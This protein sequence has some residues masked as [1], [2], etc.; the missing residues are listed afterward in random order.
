MKLRT[1]V[2]VD[3]YNLYYGRL[4]N[5]HHK[6]LDLMA[7]TERVLAGIYFG[8]K[9]RTEFELHPLAIKY[10]TASILA[11]FAK[12]KDSVSD[13]EHYHQALQ[14]HSGGA[15]QIIKGVYDASPAKAHLYQKGEPA[16]A[17]EKVEI[18]KLVEK[19]SD[20]A[21]ALHAYSDAIRGE[22]DHVVIVTNDTD[23]VPALKLIKEHTQVKI[24]IIAT[25]RHKDMAVNQD[26]DDYSDWTRVH[27]LDDELEASQLPSLIRVA[28]T[29]KVVQKPISWYP[30]PEEFVPIFDEV[31]R[32]RGSKGSAMKWL[33]EPCE[34]L[35]GRVPLQMILDDDELKELK[36]YMAAYAREHG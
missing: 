7:M 5:T 22:I 23:I 10:F 25:T 31:R 32:V 4:K 35:G 27:I 6:W 19:Q 3:G 30:R 21:L 17:C 16:R 24:G 14:I 13:Q 11:N 33:N 26:L 36:E 18:W 29:G 9:D 1:R 34:R 15:V 8:D 2:Y 12:S 20:V 28:D